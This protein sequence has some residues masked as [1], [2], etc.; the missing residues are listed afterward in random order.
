MGE[1]VPSCP[2]L[3]NWGPHLGV[4]PGQTVPSSPQPPSVILSTLQAVAPVAWQGGL[5]TPPSSQAAS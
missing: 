4:T 2:F 5:L 1:T 3:E